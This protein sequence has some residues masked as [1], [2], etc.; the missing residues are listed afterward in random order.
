MLLDKETAGSRWH[1]RPDGIDKVAG[2]LTYLTDMRLPDMLFGKILRSSHPHAWI[3][4]IDTKRAEQLS[5]VHAV[6]TYKDVPGMNLFGIAT[7]DQPVL[8]E[9]RVRYIG[10]A[11]AAVAAE[12]VEIAEYALS[13]I[14]VLY[15]PLP[16]IDSPE[17]G[18][19]PDSPKL[20]PNGNVLHRTE[21][22]RGGAMDAFAE[23]AY[24]TENTYRTPRQMH[25][26]METE[27]GLFVP[28]K[29]GGLTVYAPT[30]HGYKDRMQLSRILAI[31]ESAIRVVS[32]PIGGS[33]GGKDELNVQPYGALL[34]FNSGR[35][36]KLHQSR[37]ESVRAGLKRH[38]MTVTMKT[39]MDKDGKLLA[40]TV[41]IV[42]DTGAYAT[43]GA[44][45]L[46]FSTEHA[47]GPYRI[48]HV[49]IEGVSVYTNNGVSGE[50]RGFGGNQI[51]FALE[52]QMNRLAE[53]AGLDYWKL[54]SLNLRES[55]DLGPFEQRIVPTDGARQV[56]ESVA[57]SELMKK[58]ASIDKS[59]PPWIRHG[60]GAAIAMHGS[61]LGYGLP[62]PAGGRLRLNRQ[63][64]IEASFGYEEFGQGLIATLQI[65][66]IERFGCGK[67]DI[68]I[69][70]GDTARVPHS[71][72]S[73]ASRATSM[74]WQALA[75]MGPVFSEKLLEAASELTGISAASL[76]TGLG[77]IWRKYPETMEQ[78]R[79]E[80]AQS[81]Q[82]IEAGALIESQTCSRPVISYRELAEQTEAES[83][84][85][86]SQFDFPT[87]PD[88][89]FGAHYLHTYT[90]V[91]VEVEVNL[92]TGKVK[93]TDQ[94]HAVAA[95]PVVNPMGYVGQIEGAS[96]MALG[97]TLSEDAVMKDGRYLTNNFDT[98]LIPTIKDVPDHL[99]L[100]AIDELPEG[101]PFGPRGVGEIGTVA[102]APA[103]IA[104]VHQAVGKWVQH[105]PI[106]PEE[107]M[108]DQMFK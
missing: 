14:D 55:T 2:K 32:S 26:Y 29:D 30:Q 40:H 69:V 82:N 101:D 74:M 19:H 63:G 105:L 81:K 34:A 100:D 90:A 79:D 67:E 49:S 27:G 39:G 77:G 57:G 13:L 95:G 97:F 43:L 102:V 23:C 5:G 85:C 58:R 16:V 56:W 18:L 21:Y 75:R 3:L 24:V 15:E 36:V 17:A 89:I 68:E 107:L 44:P 76:T 91:A 103:I 98:Y 60:V 20:H 93:V 72:S 50:F 96:S 48:P 53:A 38:P 11:V 92:L 59:S 62:D 42:A 66:L 37:F 65:L 80:A 108:S 87:T 9:D 51:I 22:H 33:F 41:Q 47:Q 31:P 104:A 86:E 4:S 10:D 8:C 70:I 35:P 88:E 84:E 52:G 94:Y 46:N 1:V 64:L 12:T 71:G 83:I 6:I 73:T 25:A 106:A 99:Q 45:V 28:E 7:P 61:G 54:R 78:D